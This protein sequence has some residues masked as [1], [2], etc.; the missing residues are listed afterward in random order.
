M[1]GIIVGGLIELQQNVN[2]DILNIRQE[3]D[4]GLIELQ[5]N[6]NTRRFRHYN[7][8]GKRLNRTTVECKWDDP[9]AG[10]IDPGMA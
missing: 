6:V 7:L 1:S 2:N 5:Q 4:S 8:Y 3:I 10:K 9:G